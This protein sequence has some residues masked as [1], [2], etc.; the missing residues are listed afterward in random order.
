MP[1]KYDGRL[2]S[3]LDVRLKNGSG[4]GHHGTA[5]FGLTSGAFNIA[6]PLAKNTTYM[7]G[8]RRSWYDLLSIPFLAFINKHQDKKTKFHYYFMDLN[9]KVSHRFS[10]KASGFVSVYFGDD[11]LEVGEES[12]QELYDYYSN[13]NNFNY[14]FHWGNLV[15][16]TGL[17]YRI[18]QAMTAEFTA[19][20]TRFFSDLRYYKLYR[21]K[22]STIKEFENR[23][24]SENNINDWIF[25][26]DFDWQPDDN[27]KV[28]FGA[29]YVRHSFLPARYEKIT[30]EEDAKR[31]WRDSIFA[32]HADEVNAYIEDDW[33]INN[34]WRVNA[35]FHVSLFNIDHKVK[36]GLSPRLSVS[37]RPVDNVAVK[38]AFSRTTQYVHQ[39]T[40]SY[41][42]L[43]T[44]QWVPVTGDIKP[45][46]AEKIAVGGYWQFPGN[47]YAFSVEA[48]YKWMHNIVD[49]DDEYYLKPPSE[50]WN[51]RLIQGRGSAKGIDFKIEKLSGKFTGH[52]AYSLA[53]AD[54]TF[55]DKNG[56]LT[57]P[58][59]FDQ[60]HSINVL[61]NWNISKKV[62][63]NASWTGHS[64]NRYTLSAQMW[65]QPD[66]G[67]FEAFGN[68]YAP[69][70]SPV[71]NYQLPFYHRL[72]LSCTVRNR[73]G[74]WTFGLYNAYNHINVIA[75]C[76]G[77]KE[78]P[79]KDEGGYMIKHVPSFQKVKFLPI[80]PSISY[81]GILKKSFI[82]FLPLLLSACYENF[83]PDIDV[84]PV[85]C[86]N[87]LITAG[88]PIT[89]NVSHT[90]VYT[91][92]Y[93]TDYDKVNDAQVDIYANGVLVGEGYLPI[94]GDH[95]KIIAR[96][97]I[98]GEAEA[99]VVVPAEVPIDN[100]DWH[101]EIFE[102]QDSTDSYFDAF[103]DAFGYRIK[104][105]AKLTIPDPPGIHNF[106]QFTY[107]GFPLDKIKY[108]YYLPLNDSTV[109]SNDSPVCFY[110]G[111]LNY[112]VEPIFIEH[113]G[114]VDLSGGVECN[115][116]TFFTDSQFSG[117][118]Y[119]LNIQ[120]FDFLFDLDMDKLSEITDDM[121][122]CGL[123]LNLNSI[124]LSYYNLCNYRWNDNYGQIPSLGDIGLADP[125]YGYSNVSTG[126]GVV[127]AQATSSYA[128]DLK[129]FLTE[130][131]LDSAK[132]HNKSMLQI[133]K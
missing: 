81:M 66:F 77:D 54:R 88:E 35:G 21:S 11:R 31:V 20:Y 127:A 26:G 130:E 18:N 13:M 129:D 94:E 87:S 61:V 79:E 104:I 43:P 8:V 72:D 48:Y 32:Y 95:I 73:R 5:K 44:D 75:I 60:R 42:S 105:Y 47:S 115:G 96:S 14:V 10:D 112:K 33:R 90:W 50:I 120:F 118:S 82:L 51:A 3:Y 62:S 23:L 117:D 17:N 109:N 122:S 84:K 100:V 69:L 53:W 7:L 113:I 110:P 56:G 98:Y 58:A 22:T 9:A 107:V 83:T 67:K 80:I 86:I 85:L 99:E 64:G 29:N 123:I 121:L 24:N 28:R 116:Y 76:R 52:I 91:D 6:G 30:I 128:I 133:V 55:P 49:Y 70:R 132:S 40:E 131:I 97:A 16:Q 71:N 36:Y 92:T 15:A 114:Q 68:I 27:N 101:A 12:S 2:S 102:R 106:Y 108:P 38:A 41:I 65:H 78:V 111:Y 4:S 126:A 63:L 59:R 89:V 34:K 124:S 19:A 39:L 93:A 57:F 46:T 25:R 125:R 45:Q 37:Y 1:A 74:Y 103:Y 119:T